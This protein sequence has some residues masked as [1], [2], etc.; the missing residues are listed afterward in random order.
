MCGR[1]AGRTSECVIHVNSRNQ[2]S[3]VFSLQLVPTLSL[4]RTQT[5]TRARDEPSIRGAPSGVMAWLDRHNTEVSRKSGNYTHAHT[6]RSL[7]PTYQTPEPQPPVGTTFYIDDDPPAVGI[8]K[9]GKKSKARGDFSIV[10]ES[11]VEAGAN[12][13]YLASVTRAVD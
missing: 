13:G 3:L 8:L 12:T 4:A 11:L 10:L 2:Y 9:C 7:Y 6:R 1:S 5:R